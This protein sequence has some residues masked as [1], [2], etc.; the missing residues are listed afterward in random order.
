[1]MEWLRGLATTGYVGA[2]ALDR[3]VVVDDVDAAL[4]ACAP[5][6]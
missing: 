6:G 2:G 4:A 5:T 1:L 3:L